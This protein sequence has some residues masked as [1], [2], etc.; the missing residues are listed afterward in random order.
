[1]VQIGKAGIARIEQIAGV[2]DSVDLFINCD[3]DGLSECISEIFTSDIAPVLS[4]P[5]MRV[6]YV[7]EFRGHLLLIVV[8]FGG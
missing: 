5:E 4:I 3:F 7:E 8:M 6:G 1:L 2:N